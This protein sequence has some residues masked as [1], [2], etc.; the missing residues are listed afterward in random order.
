M[1][2]YFLF[3]VSYSLL[4]ALVFHTMVNTYQTHLHAHV[5]NPESSL[6]IC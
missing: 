5:Q 3:L 4:S 2:R 6:Q 1:I